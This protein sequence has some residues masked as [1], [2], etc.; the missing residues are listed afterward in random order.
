MTSIGKEANQPLLSGWKQISTFQTPAGVVE[1]GVIV[2]CSLPMKDGIL[3]N[4]LSLLP[5]LVK[6]ATQRDIP[7][8]HVKV[9]H[10]NQDL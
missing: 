4:S 3:A 7:A 8:L 1:V 6:E 2:L 9:N 10:Q 5:F